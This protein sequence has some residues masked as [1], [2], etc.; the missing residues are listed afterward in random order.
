MAQSRLNDHNVRPDQETLAY[1]LRQWDEPYRST[2]H[3]YDFIADK[4]ADARRV[5][6]LGC[7]AGG[8][9]GFI[10]GSFPEVNFL[11]VDVSDELLQ[12]AE[13]RSRLPNLAFERDNLENLKVRFGVDGVTMMQTL[14]TLPDPGLPLHMIATRIR[15]QWLALSTLIYEGNIDCRI[16]VSEALVPRMQ[17][18][19]IFGLPTLKQNMASQGYRFIKHRAFKIDADLPKPNNPDIMATYTINTENGRLQCSGPLILPWGFVMFER[20][21]STDTD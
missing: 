6:D 13:H 7:G 20:N 8:A 19:N 9:I 18:Y 17:F 16:V 15:P 4:L 5:V 10:A 14:H 1:H 21:A 11:G 2:V 3:F 12:C